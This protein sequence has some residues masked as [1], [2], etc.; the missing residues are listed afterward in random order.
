MS[1]CAQPAAA[2]PL[3]TRSGGHG[4]TTLLIE[5]QIGHQPPPRSCP[6]W[7]LQQQAG[8]PLTRP[9]KYPAMTETSRSALGKAAAV[10]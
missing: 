10:R 8:I 9:A 6:P 7:P 3:P 5:N 4:V 1:G 2:D